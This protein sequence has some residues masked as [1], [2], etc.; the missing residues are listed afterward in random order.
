MGHKIINQSINHC[1]SK[2]SRTLLKLIAYW[3]IKDNRWAALSPWRHP[4]EWSD[5]V[6]GM[7]SGKGSFCLEWKTVGVMDGRWQR[8]WWERSAHMDGT[9]RV[10]RRMIKTWLTEWSKKLTPKT[11][12]C[13]SKWAVLESYVVDT[14]LIVL[15][16]VINENAKAGARMD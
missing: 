9:K 7:I 15:L 4:D 13:I 10:W 8:W 2:T 16:N 1:G 5:S 6:V 12:W 3:K 11:R 14:G